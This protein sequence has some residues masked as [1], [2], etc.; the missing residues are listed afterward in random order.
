MEDL[1]KRA[2][3]DIAAAKLVTALTGAGISTESGIPPFRG[4]GGLWERFNPMEVAHID[5]F[6]QDPARVWDILLKEMK[7]IVEAAQPNDSHRGLTK[8]EKIGKLSTIITQ[9]VDGLHQ[10]AGSTD[11]IEFHGNFAS[12]RCLDCHKQYATRDVQVTQVPPRCGCNGIL[13]PNAV[14]FGELIPPEA[15]RRSQ[16][17]A[18]DCDLMLVLGTSAEVQPAAMMP[19]IAKNTGATIIEINPQSTAL[20]AAVSDYLIK[21]KAGEVMNRIIAELERII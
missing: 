3:E 17:I 10:A 12:H 6:M 5:A 18:T 20:T 13:R 14:F 8:L 9:N 11:V 15:L 21:G 7:T 4:K 2:A 1:I 19:V 16:Q